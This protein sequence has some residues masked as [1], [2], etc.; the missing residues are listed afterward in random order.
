M[1]PPPKAR[2]AAKSDMASSG[3]Y[4]PPTGMGPLTKLQWKAYLLQIGKSESGNNY[5]CK[6]TLN[7]VGKYQF[8]AAALSQSGI[9]YVK[10]DYVEKYKQQTVLQPGAW[11][12]K[13]GINSLDDWFNSP[14]AQEAAMYTYTLANYNALVRNGGIKDGDDL[15][16]IMGMLAASHLIGPGGFNKKQGKYVGALGW[17]KGEGG[18]DAYGTTGSTY[19]A[20]GKYAAEVLAVPTNVS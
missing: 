15:C 4:D 9:G 17:R 18:G 11:T 2:V 19:F 13:G 7:Y 10:A 12:G 1:G 20:I 14:A 8:G 3:T 16:T 6:N 5:R